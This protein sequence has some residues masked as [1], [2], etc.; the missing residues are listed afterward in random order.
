MYDDGNSQ[1]PL[2]PKAGSEKRKAHDFLVP[3]LFLFARFC[4]GLAVPVLLVVILAFLAQN[5]IGH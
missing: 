1:D 5:A 2:L 4:L 3:A